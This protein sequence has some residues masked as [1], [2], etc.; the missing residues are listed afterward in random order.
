MTAPSVFKVR[1]CGGRWYIDEHG[2]DGSVSRTFK[3]FPTEEE[4]Q[5][6]ADRLTEAEARIARYL[7][8]RAAGEEAPRGPGRA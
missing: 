4:A 7:A 1:G 2:A 3:R 8:R 6:E 5:E